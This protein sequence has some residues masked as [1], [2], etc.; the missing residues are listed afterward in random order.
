MSKRSYLRVERT[1]TSPQS[2]NFERETLNFI[3]RYRFPNCGCV[4][5][6]TSDAVDA[7]FDNKCINDYEIYTYI[8]SQTKI[9]PNYII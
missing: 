7:A 8:Y 3:Y 1:I 4:S 9:K 5:E 6:K 2:R